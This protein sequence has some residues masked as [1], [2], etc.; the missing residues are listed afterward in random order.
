MTPT[1]T[2]LAQTPAGVAVLATLVGD[3]I[4]PYFARMEGA[5]AKLC[6]GPPARAGGCAGGCGGSSGSS[7]SSGGCAGGSCSVGGGSTPT[8]I[9]STSTQGVA[10][11]TG[12]GLCTAESVAGQVTANCMSGPPTETLCTRQ[13][14]QLQKRSSVYSYSVLPAA[15]GAAEG[16]GY[17]PYTPAGV[18]DITFI[19]NV[20]A[21]DLAAIVSIC[22]FEVEVTDAT[23]G[24][25]N[26]TGKVAGL[27]SARSAWYATQDNVV[28]R[29]SQSSGQEFGRKLLTYDGHC[30]CACIKAWAPYETGVQ[31][32]FT[33]PGLKVANIAATSLITVRFEAQR[34]YAV[35]ACGFPEQC[36]EPD[37]ADPRATAL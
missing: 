5:L 4:Q 34:C 17:S 27:A 24:S 18:G 36:N 32:E 13:N 2:N 37:Y 23:A 3:A 14:R 22:E 9:P 25:F 8:P 21:E 19:L 33:I 1:N 35:L 10:M 31:V 11:P 29:V 20:P 12:P 26:Y 28:S 7:G 16:I 6:D 15:F 30:S